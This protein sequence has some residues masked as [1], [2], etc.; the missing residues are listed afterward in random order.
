MDYDD[1]SEFLSRLTIADLD[2][3]LL[4]LDTWKGESRFHETFRACATTAMVTL[5]NNPPRLTDE[6]D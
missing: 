6:T 1:I 3:L 5:R 4:V 2:R